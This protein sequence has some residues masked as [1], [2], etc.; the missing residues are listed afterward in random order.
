MAASAASKSIDWDKCI[1]CQQSSKSSKTTCPA[2]S[3]RND[4]GCGYKSLAETVEGYM[5]LGQLSLDIN[6]SLWNDGDGIEA[7]LR[8]H[9][10]CWHRKCRNCFVHATTLQR[11]RVNN[12][13]DVPDDDL[14]TLSSTVDDNGPLSSTVLDGPCCKSLRL[15]RKSADKN[16][17]EQDRSLC[18]FSDKP[19]DL[20]QVMTWSVDQQVRKCAALTKDTVLLGKLVQGD[21]EAKYHHTCLLALYRRAEH[22]QTID[23]T[24]SEPVH[25]H[26]DPE[27]LALADVISYIEDVKTCSHAHSIEA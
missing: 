3:K 25:D 10:A 9:S 27:S 13:T 6:L 11:L 8:R 5:Q 17:D 26:V 14:A 23:A 7:T 19:G 18:F 15:T 1:F 21:I 24:V 4:I 16:G 22:L 2:Q 20:R 12:G